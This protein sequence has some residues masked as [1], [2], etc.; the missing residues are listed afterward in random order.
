WIN[1]LEAPLYYCGL[2]ALLLAPQAFAAMDAR[3]RKL[4]GALAALVLLPTVFPYFR[5]LL[6]AFSGNYYRSYS[7]FVVA[8][9]V[10]FAARGLSALERGGRVRGLT[11]AATLAVLLA[12]L[13]LFPAAFK[14]PRGW[15]DMGLAAVLAAALS[16]DAGL[17]ALL[18]GQKR[19]RA[20]LALLLASIVVEAGAASWRTIADRP[21]VTAEE[22]SAK[23]GYSDFT[24][25][26]LAALRAADPSFYRVEK[27][28]YSSPAQYFGYNDSKAQNYFGSSA[29]AQFNEA[30]SLAFLAELG[31][32]DP[33]NEI[34]TRWVHGLRDR[35]NLMSLTGVK[36]YL[37]KKERPAFFADGR[38]GSYGDVTVYRNRRALPLG[39]TYDHCLPYADFARLSVASR[40]AA[41]FDAFVPQPGAD[42]LG[43]S[44]LSAA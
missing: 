19:A 20:A 37:S 2:A 23:Q 24:V 28:Y 12:L 35:E 41:L 42:C 8:I 38:M 21:V 3:R 1:Y 10:F 26:A 25:D 13:F 15:V 5:Y 32:L 34:D 36:Y 4:Y 30:S 16:V 17:I 31:V 44:A 33:A 27:D 22:L 29:Y 14:A 7:M 40:E 9:L 18:G 6:W 43:F 39:F 11:L